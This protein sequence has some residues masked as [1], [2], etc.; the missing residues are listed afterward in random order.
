MKRIINN[1]FFLVLCIS[2]AFAACN[3]NDENKG[4]TTETSK[5]PEQKT[6]NST[7]GKDAVSVDPAHY[8]VLADTLGIRMV[9]VNYKP[10]DS[11]ALHWHPDYAIYTAGGG[12]VTFYDKDGKA[13]AVT[14]PDGATMIKSGEWHSAKNTGTKPIKVIL[15]EVNRNGATGTNDPATDAAKVASDVYKVKNDTMGIRIL[16]ITAK[17][18]GSVAMHAHPD[19]A[20]YVMDG[21]TTEF[22]FKDG[23]KRVTELK[24]GMS[25]IL[26]AEAHSAHN[27]G[28]TTLHAILVEVNRAMK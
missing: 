2:I 4:A 22:T 7:A 24:T 11:S 26:P 10:G 9:E 5:A 20:I 16:E 19:G 6:D 23:T 13:N 15:V 14:L 25:M 1:Q 3:N 18:G 17:P 21:G 27:T 8:K 12:T 28:K